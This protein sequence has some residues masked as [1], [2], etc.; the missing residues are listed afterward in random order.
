MTARKLL[1]AERL[2]KLGF[3]EIHGGERGRWKLP[4]S[5]KCWGKVS[6]G[7]YFYSWASEPASGDKTLGA[8][9][10]VLR[11]EMTEP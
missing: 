11:S 10:E 8:T 5:M 9:G 2:R 3:S 4:F 6:N 1:L 7:I